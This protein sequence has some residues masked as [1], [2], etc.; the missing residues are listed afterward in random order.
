MPIEEILK[1]LRSIYVWI[2]TS[3]PVAR[4]KVADLI[5]QLGGVV[6]EQHSG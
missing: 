6:P 1:Q 4:N 3:T 2:P 5:R